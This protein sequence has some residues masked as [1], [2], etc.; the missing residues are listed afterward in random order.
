MI[1]IHNPFAEAMR[2]ASRHAD[3]EL[4]HVRRLLAEDRRALA[5][6]R[7]R[8]YY[9]PVGVRLTRRAEEAVCR[10]LDELWVA[11]GRVA[12]LEK[13]FGDIYRRELPR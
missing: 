6:W 12:I 2:F 9:G 7:T 3:A 4:R 5:Y 10:R 1:V 11:Q 13:A 8:K